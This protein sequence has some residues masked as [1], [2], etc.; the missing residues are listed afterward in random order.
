MPYLTKIDASRQIRQVSGTTFLLSGSTVI[1]ETLEIQGNFSGSSKIFSGS[2]DLSKLFATIVGSIGSYVDSSGDTMTGPLIGTTITAV[3]ITGSTISGYSISATTLYS[4]TLS[5]ITGGVNIQG[6]LIKDSAFSGDSLHVRSSGNTI[7]DLKY[8]NKINSMF[9]GINGVFP[10]TE[11]GV[12]FIP[13]NSGLA[14]AP[15]NGFA[16]FG[17]FRSDG[18]TQIRQ[19]PLAGNTTNARRIKINEDNFGLI[20]IINGTG[21]T[22][23]IDGYT[24]ST[25]WTAPSGITV[26]GKF[27]ATTIY[28]GSSN[29]NTLFVNN[30]G[31]G[32]NINTGGTVNKPIINLNQDISVNSLSGTSISGNTIKTVIFSSST[33]F[34]NNAGYVGIKQGDWIALNLPYAAATDTGLW[35]NGTAT[36]L[37]S[38]IAGKHVKISTQ[39]GS[40]EI[41][42]NT[43]GGVQRMALSTNVLKFYNGVAIDA[44][45][46]S[47]DTISGSSISANTEYI[48]QYI[49][50]KPLTTL[51]ASKTGRIFFSG[52]TLNACMYNS[53][54]TATDWVV[55][56]KTGFI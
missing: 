23:N 13:A 24:G 27:S 17:D 47:G 1:K 30:I 16:I 51:P 48:D 9:V 38:D 43:G 56:N 46:I 14:G 40:G 2:T 10:P 49:D 36:I 19:G 18:F 53:G 32:T 20:E 5:A 39:T 35:Y 4:N 52:G 3:N 50:L 22:L 6:T 15:T 28:S 44:L 33:L 54:G 11:Q 45:A 42:F 31:Q 29:I 26:T 21:D 12:A 41:Q 34:D 37:Y 8:S 55:M 25:T 7:V